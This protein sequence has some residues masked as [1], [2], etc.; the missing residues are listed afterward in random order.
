MIGEA[1][2]RADRPAA[3]PAAAVAVDAAETPAPVAV[4]AQSEPHLEPHLEPRT[5]PH[6]Q[7]PAE[8][9]A[10]PATPALAVAAARPVAEPVA[11][12]ADQAPGT[13]RLSTPAEPPRAYVLPADTL[14]ALAAEAGLQ[15][16]GSDADKVRA[17]Q[18]AMAAE[19]AP[20]RVPREPRPPVVIDEGPLVLVETRKDLSQMKL[21]FEQ[22]GGQHRPTA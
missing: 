12:T 9:A 14:Q 13:P 18:A 6:A 7:A 22:Q 21:P 15:W 17:V 16:I 5:E 20:I 10:Q 11:G 1:E 3:G 8:A 4:E 19:P 2:T